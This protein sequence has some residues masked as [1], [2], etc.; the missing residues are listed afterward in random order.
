MA[1]IASD[2]QVSITLLIHLH[3]DSQAMLH[4]AAN[5][6]FHKRTKHIQIDCDFVHDAVQAVFFSPSH[7]RS[8][9][10]PADI[11]IKAL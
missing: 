4:I 11:L 9:L 8:E 2:L 7:L 1:L 3:C 5:S 10:Q 6:I